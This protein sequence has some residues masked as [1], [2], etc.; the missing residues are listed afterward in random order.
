M[1]RLFLFL[2]R[3]NFINKEGKII[4]L[5]EETDSFDD[6]LDKS[7]KLFNLKIIKIYLNVQFNKFIEINELIQLQNND[8]IYLEGSLNDEIKLNDDW[9]TL[10]IGG[11][12][13]TTTRSTITNR[14]PDSM[15]S[16]MFNND[17]WKNTCN[18]NGSILIDRSFKYFEPIINY[19]RHGKLIIDPGMSVYGVLEEARFYS[20][21]NLIELCDKEIKKREEEQRLLLNPPPI[22]RREIMNI[23]MHSKN[24]TYLRFQSI[25][26]KGV[27][28][29]RLDLSWIN[30]KYA[31]LSG[32]NLSGSNIS[33]SNF[34]RAD[35]SKANLENCKCYGVK[36]TC[37]NLESSILTNADFE[38]PNGTNITGCFI[39]Y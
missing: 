10:N 2:K 4:I 39:E 33:F 17:C 36:M 14:E 29:S 26:L 13:Y 35:L 16:K 18:E 30:F 25:E 11:K 23:L 6:L 21:D 37:V 1:K 19:L 38:D 31:N 5:N 27:D 12:S 24:E 15:L 22:T 32:S 20:M 8:H 34:E 7:R 28:L 9:I 3:N